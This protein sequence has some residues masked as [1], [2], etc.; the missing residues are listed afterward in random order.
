M[1]VGL[2]IY[3]LKRCALEGSGPSAVTV[4]VKGSEDLG[5]PTTRH[6]M[7]SHVYFGSERPGTAQE[8]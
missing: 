1:W 8:R 3:Y 2:A 4:S 6:D 7:R 5:A